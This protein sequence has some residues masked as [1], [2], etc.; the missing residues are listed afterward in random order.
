MFNFQM[1][2]DPCVRKSTMPK[3][4][5]TP[6]TN[7]R[8][9]D[10]DEVVSNESK[11][12]KDSDKLYTL[13]VE[14]SVLKEDLH[15]SDS[16]ETN[17]AIE[18]NQDNVTD[19]DSSKLISTL[20]TNNDGFQN[21]KI[22]SSK[23]KSKEFISD[24][25]N[26]DEQIKMNSII[27]QIVET[28]I[29]KDLDVNK[30]TLISPMALSNKINQ[31]RHIYLKGTKKGT[32]CSEMSKSEFCS[33]HKNKSSDANKINIEEL[34]HLKIQNSKLMEEINSMKKTVQELTTKSPGVHKETIRRLFI[35]NFRLKK[36]LEKTQKD[37]KESK[38][39]LEKELKI[40]KKK[41]EKIESWVS[42]KHKC[43]D[44][45]AITRLKLKNLKRNAT[46]KLVKFSKDNLAEVDHQGMKLQ[47]II[48]KTME[49]RDESEGWGLT[50]SEDMKKF[51]WI[52]M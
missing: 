9:R 44:Q 46:Y 5:T 31:C 32:R 16:D 25:E 2:Q 14:S 23:F 8:P 10:E 40:T 19:T 6:P 50:Y 49:R 18:Q 35:Q 15:L 21:S 36:E 3:P 39:H 43:T 26:E 42:N 1:S 27:E 33:G 29:K 52:K 41:L 45:P 13:L 48:P 11:L 51:D 7:K 24:S 12:R 22:K 28:N 38:E 37:L 17:N 47:V 34:H 30:T 20:A 4:V